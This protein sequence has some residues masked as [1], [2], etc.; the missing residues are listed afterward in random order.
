[1]PE[2]KCCL[3]VFPKT[4]IPNTVNLIYS[5]LAY[6]QM[7]ITLK[8]FSCLNNRYIMHKTGNPTSR[9]SI[10]GLDSLIADYATATFFTAPPN[11]FR[12]NLMGS[13]LLS[14][15]AFVSE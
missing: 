3:D 12:K 11:S 7:D 2:F 6:L 15:H 13:S 14:L 4:M 10:T 1:M 9:S 5:Y 8:Q